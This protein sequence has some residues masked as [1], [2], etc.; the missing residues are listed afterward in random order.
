MIE[1]LTTTVEVEAW[2]LLSIV[3]MTGAFVVLTSVRQLSNRKYLDRELKR[4]LEE[5]SKDRDQQA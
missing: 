5:A 3:G 4:R 2:W 1:F